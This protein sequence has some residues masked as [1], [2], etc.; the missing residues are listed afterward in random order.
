MPMTTY[1]GNDVR[2]SKPLAD[3][4]TDSLVLGWNAKMVME[5]T[6]KLMMD[7]VGN[8]DGYFGSPTGISFTEAV[9]KMAEMESFQTQ[10]YSESYN[11][12]NAIN[13]DIRSYVNYE[14][15]YVYIFIYRKQNN[16][17]STSALTGEACQFVW[18]L[19]VDVDINQ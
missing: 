4:V 14:D 13:K 16:V 7:R 5:T 1:M 10:N 9:Y 18:Q 17:C 12:I 11:L 3:G 19:L 8:F 15:R 6:Q 2:E